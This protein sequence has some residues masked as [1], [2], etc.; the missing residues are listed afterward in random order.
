MGLF[1]TN[2]QRKRQWLWWAA[3][4][5]LVAFLLA[6]HGFTAWQAERQFKKAQEDALAVE[7]A[8]SRSPALWSNVTVTVVPGKNLVLVEGTVATDADRDTLRQTIVSMG[9][10]ASVA[11]RLTR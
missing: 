11:V 9:I 3:S 1:S 8:L 2:Q 4:G 7:A 10:T 5:F 6:Y